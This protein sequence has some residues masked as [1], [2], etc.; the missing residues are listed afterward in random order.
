[1]R[2]VLTWHPTS[3]GSGLRFIDVDNR[4]FLISRR[5]KLIEQQDHDFRVTIEP[6]DQGGYCS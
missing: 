3:P 1:M 2:G 4:E 5:G 6:T